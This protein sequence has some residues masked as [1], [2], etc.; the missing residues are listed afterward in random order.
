MPEPSTHDDISQLLVA[1]ATFSLEDAAGRDGTLVLRT[2]KLFE[3][4]EYPDKQFSLSESELEAAVA[5]FV[6]VKNNLEHTRTV[7]D[8]QLGEV[9]SVERRGKE[10]F[11]AVAIPGWLDRLVGA[12]PLKVSL[13]WARDSKQ[14]VGNA[15]VLNPRIPDAQLVAAFAAATEKEQSIMSFV[16]KIKAFFTGD[17]LPSEE[18]LKAVFTAATQP[19]GFTVES[20]AGLQRQLLQSQA[21]AW[22]NTLLTA[23]Q[24]LPAEKANAIALFTQAALTDAGNTVCFAEDGALKEGAMLAAVKASFASRPQHHLTTEHLSNLVTLSNEKPKDDKRLNEL[25]EQSR[26]AGQGVRS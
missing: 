6:P 22:F 5:A 25:R 24:V 17:K 26:F 15:L 10:L 16:E 12:S 11:G 7:L 13:E 3:T 9:R 19:T 4:G 2:G 14:I 1:P 18:E 23:N 21:E 20:L 8:S